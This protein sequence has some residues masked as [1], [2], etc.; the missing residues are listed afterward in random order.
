ML[1][2]SRPL[3]GFVYPHSGLLSQALQ[4][5][6]HARNAHGVTHTEL[7]ALLKAVTLSGPLLLCGQFPDPLGRPPKKSALDKG[8]PLGSIVP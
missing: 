8:H 7:F 3:P 4:A 1:H 2:S 6:F 5:L